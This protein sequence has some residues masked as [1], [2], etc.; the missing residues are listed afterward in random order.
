MATKFCKD[1][2]W[3]RYDAFW[4]DCWHYSLSITTPQCLVTGKE[5]RTELRCKPAEEVRYAGGRGQ[6]GKW[7]EPK[8]PTIF[9]RFCMWF[10]I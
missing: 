4:I 7:W 5:E 3:A 1:C 6:E 8:P 10:G 2:K 9:Q